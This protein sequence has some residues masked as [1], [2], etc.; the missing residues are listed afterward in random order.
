MQYLIVFLL[1]GGIAGTSSLPWCPNITFTGADIT[2]QPY[3]SI[4]SWTCDGYTII[5]DAM[6]LFDTSIA[7]K[8]DNGTVI[9]SNLIEDPLFSLGESHYDII[10]TVTLGSF[11]NPIRYNGPIILTNKNIS[12]TKIELACIYN[13]RIVYKPV[14]E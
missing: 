12:F 2:L 13:I 7:A 9:V 10:T 3:K 5:C 11:W 4:G 14:I 8:I 1:V 6:V